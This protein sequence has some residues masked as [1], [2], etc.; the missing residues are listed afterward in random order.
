MPMSKWSDP[1]YLEFFRRGGLKVDFDTLQHQINE[2]YRSEG[3]VPP[4]PT[5]LEMQAIHH[6][7]P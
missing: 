4:A 5:S 3:K 1:T 6:P 7:S 2:R